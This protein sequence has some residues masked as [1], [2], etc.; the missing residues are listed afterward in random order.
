MM[1]NMD[2]SV[3]GM[4]RGGSAV[5]RNSDIMWLDANPSAEFVVQQVTDVYEGRSTNVGP[6]KSEVW[7]I[8]QRCP[9]LH[10]STAE[11]SLQSRDGFV[12]VGSRGFSSVQLESFTQ[13]PVEEEKGAPPA[14]S[15][16]LVTCCAVC[17]VG[18]LKPLVESHSISRDDHRMDGWQTNCASCSPDWISDLST[19]VGCDGEEEASMLTLHPSWK[20]PS[21]GGGASGEQEPV[22]VRPRMLRDGSG[23][24]ML[25]RS[26][27]VRTG[28]ST[29]NL[30]ALGRFSGAPSYT[31]LE[32][33]SIPSPV[34][35][36]AGG[37][38]GRAARVIEDDSRSSS[39]LD[40]V[41]T[42]GVGRTEIAPLCTST[43]TVPPSVAR[44]GS[45]GLRGSS[46][47]SS[48]EMTERRRSKTAVTS[49]GFSCSGSSRPALGSRSREMLSSRL[50]PLTQTLDPHGPSTTETDFHGTELSLLPVGSFDSSLR[51]PTSIGHRR[52]SGFTLPIQVSTSPLLPPAFRVDQYSYFCFPP[53][54]ERRS[55]LFTFEIS[56]VEDNR[57]GKK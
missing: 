11:E 37:I 20:V 36:L 27:A 6:S 25:L 1:Q 40:S 52:M 8:G 15:R 39:P 9:A 57:E 47:R 48:R 35:G 3:D 54:V 56:N 26:G 29:A 19:L 28:S 16:T 13:P 12:E 41:V 45:R 23:G 22:R 10:C 34:A 18:S 14:P 49:E 32:E 17:S 51:F 5:R 53:S 4:S 30:P 46:R 2:F 42:G 38:G 33:A 43:C 21:A 24:Y 7:T 55:S 50:A 31:F 44:Q